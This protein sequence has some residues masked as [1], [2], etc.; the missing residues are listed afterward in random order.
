[1]GIVSVVFVSKVCCSVTKCH[2][3][4]NEERKTNKNTRQK[5]KQPNSYSVNNSKADVIRI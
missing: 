3:Q 5:A 4:V 2:I 1:M